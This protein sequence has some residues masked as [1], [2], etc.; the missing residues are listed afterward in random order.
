MREAYDILIR[1]AQI[2]DGSGENRYVSDVGIRDGKI[3]RIG[4]LRDC[5]GE[6]EISA[7]GLVLTPGFMDVHSH[8]DCTLLMYPWAESCVQQGVTTVV[9]GNCGL[10]PAPIGEKWVAEFWEFD[11][12]DELCPSVYQ[13]F[14]GQVMQPIDKVRR[15]FENELGYTI[16]WHSFAE[17]LH[18]VEKRGTAVNFVP[19]VGHDRF[20]PR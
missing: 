7:Q 18:A 9:G 10:S 11:L 13:L 19:L 15:V 2:I 6:K 5:Q 3:Q 20:A 16:N 14:G 4:D 12:W 17:Y 8:A 1:R